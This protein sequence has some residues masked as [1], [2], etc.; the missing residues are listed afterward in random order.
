MNKF[1]VLFH[2]DKQVKVGVVL[3]NISNLIADIGRENL[4]IQMLTDGEAVKTLVKSTSPFRSL[5]KDLAEK[6]VEFSVCANAIRNFG[7]NRNELLDFVTVDSSDGGEIIKKK[8][9]GWSYIC[10]CEIKLTWY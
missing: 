3:T 8:A 10:L 2:M 6:Q 4:E 7:I 1:K 5:L 9:A